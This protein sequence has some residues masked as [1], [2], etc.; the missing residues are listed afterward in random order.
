MKKY[1]YLTSD[2]Q[3]VLDIMREYA[4]KI[5]DDYISSI[6]RRDIAYYMECSPSKI[7][8]ITLGLIENNFLKRRSGSKTEYVFTEEGLKA[9]EED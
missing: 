1:A 2:R 5:E 8:M 4:H 3:K 7:K 6:S 9:T